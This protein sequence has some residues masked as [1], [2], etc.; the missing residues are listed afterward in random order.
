MYGPL[1]YCWFTSPDVC[2]CYFSC[3]VCSP[4]TLP[5]FHL[6]NRTQQLK[7]QLRYFLNK[8]QL[9]VERVSLHSVLIIMMMQ[10]Q[11]FIKYLYMP[12]TGLSTLYYLAHSVFTIV[13]EGGT[14]IKSVRAWHQTV[15]LWLIYYI[16]THHCLSKA[17]CVQL[18][19][20]EYY[21]PSCL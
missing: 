21:F 7:N 1:L 2:L 20:V 9:P 16:H 11:S 14:I 15:Y 12:N 3:L 13:L 10:W 6:Y 17:G 18:Y 4:L 8:L 19:P 5:P